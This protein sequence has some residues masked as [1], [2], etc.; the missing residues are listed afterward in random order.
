[1]GSDTSI[2]A[3]SCQNCT[4]P[5]G[6]Q[7]LLSRPLYQLL[8]NDFGLFSRS[9][10]VEQRIPSRCRSCS[11]WSSS[12]SGQGQFQRQRRWRRLMALLRWRLHCR[13]RPQTS[14]RHALSRCDIGNGPTRRS[15]VGEVEESL[16][17]IA[18]GIRSRDGLWKRALRRRCLRWRQRRRALARQRAQQPSDL[19]HLLRQLSHFRGFRRILSRSLRSS[20]RRRRPSFFASTFRSF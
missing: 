11:C 2:R 16:H 20:A 10:R 3:T 13:G 5:P 12:W 8:K 19:L 6:V 15:V 14:R 4:P 9:P 17:G 18:T 1:M 7:R